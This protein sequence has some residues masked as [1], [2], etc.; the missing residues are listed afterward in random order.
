MRLK[1]GRTL[2]GT[3]SAQTEQRILLNITGTVKPIVIDSEDV[4]SVEFSSQSMMPAGLVNDLG[5]DQIRNL[6]AYLMGD[7]QVPIKD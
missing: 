1:D 4:L 6:F 5:E 2:I 7:H 3:I